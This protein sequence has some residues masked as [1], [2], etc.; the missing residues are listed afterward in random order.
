LAVPTSAGAACILSG[1]PEGPDPAIRLCAAFREF[2]DR[3]RERMERSRDIH[4]RVNAAMPLPDPSIVHG[5]ESEALKIKASE[6]FGWWRPPHNAIEPSQIETA[7]YYVRPVE[8]RVTESIMPDGK[9]AH[10]FIKIDE[11]E[12]LSKAA[13]AKHDKLTRMLALSKEY[14]A[15]HKRRLTAAG[16]DD[17]DDDADDEANR[18]HLIERALRIT[19]AKTREG[20]LAKIDL[21]LSNPD[22]FE[23]VQNGDSL[24]TSILRDVRRALSS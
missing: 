8:M 24:A 7:L 13:Q 20:I 17:G 21:Y 22:R 10:S 16:Y 6:F 2:E 18:Q 3:W 15:E 5:E 9:I 14:F 1:G 19:P 11:P 23:P 12:F 4:Q